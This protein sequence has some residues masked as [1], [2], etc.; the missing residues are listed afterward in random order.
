MTY[1]L[2]PRMHIPYTFYSL[3]GVSQLFRILRDR[4]DIDT[5]YSLMGVSVLQP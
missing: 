5:F 2:I 1:E 3:M 4:I